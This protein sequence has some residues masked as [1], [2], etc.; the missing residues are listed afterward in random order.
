D[1]RWKISGSFGYYYDVMKYELA[2]GSFGGD[3]WVSHAYL[4][5]SPNVLALGKANPGALGKEIVSY[6]NRTVPINAKGELDGI[7]PN[8]K[9][10]K[11]RRFNV[12][13]DHAFST[14]LV[15]SARYTRTDIL[16]GIE[17]IGIESGDDEVY[18]I[19][20]PGLGETR[21]PKSPWGQ[22]FP[23]GKEW[24]VPAATRQYDA[25]EFRLQGHTKDLTF[26]TSYTYSRLW[27]NWSGL[28]NADES[29]RSDPGVSRA[30]D[31]PYYY[32]DASGSQKTVFGRLGTDR[33][34]EIKFFVSHDLKSKIGVTTFGLN[35]VAFSGTP[36]TTT[37]IYHTAPT[38]PYGRADMARTPFYT[39]TD[40]G[41]N[42]NFKVSE[43]TTLRISANATNLFNQNAVVSRVTQMNR[44]GAISDALLPTAKFFTGYD[45]TKFVYP[46]NFT[47]SGLPQYNPIYAMPGGN[48]RTGGTGA[49]QGPRELRLGLRLMF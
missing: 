37:V 25:V 11:Q 4:L 29:G 15:A 16:A 10:F 9:P 3:Y 33:P 7:D 6:D 8:I 20:N 1:G 46:G 21:N 39:Q 34:N 5:D 14:R 24:L 32:I 47:V 40:L 30:F 45:V 13:V 19:G 23:N 26:L 43:R 27:G 12:S 22:K 38:T 42:H 31:S 2:R 35:Q 48:Y 17:D 18:L 28:A 49:Y 41:I 44:A 36:D